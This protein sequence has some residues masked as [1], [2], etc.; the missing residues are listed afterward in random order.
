MWFL[1]SKK[2]IKKQLKDCHP[3]FSIPGLVKIFGE[4]L[5]KSMFKFFT[6]NSLTLQKQSGFNGMTREIN[7]SY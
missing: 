6:E 7:Y 4:L 2:V 3:I 1:S 5:Y